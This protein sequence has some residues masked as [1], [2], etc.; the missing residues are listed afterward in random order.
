MVGFKKFLLRGNLVDLAVA[1]VI[2]AAFGTLVAAVVKDLI[3]PLIGA[4]GGTPSF[5]NLTFTLNQSTFQYGD[6]LNALIAFAILAAVLYFCVVVPFG[7]LL[8]RYKPTSGQPTV[9]RDCPHC[10]SAVPAAATVC[11]FCTRDLPVAAAT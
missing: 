9:T 3:T 8:E 11:A 6:F 1:V 10:L 7:R 5:S 2:G 4:I